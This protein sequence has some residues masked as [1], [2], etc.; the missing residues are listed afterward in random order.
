[1]CRKLEI[2]NVRFIP[3]RPTGKGLLGFA[4]FE[5]NRALLLNNVAVYTRPDGIGIR[6]V[7]PLHRLPNGLTV[8]LFHPTTKIAT[9]A[10]TL[11]V[12]EKL[13]ELAKFNQAKGGDK[14][15]V[16]NT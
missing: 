9:E 10:I 11:A 16:D 13:D 1:M 3:I 4:S 6:L 7:Y 8:S 15:E 2:T 14:N 12:Q 5:V